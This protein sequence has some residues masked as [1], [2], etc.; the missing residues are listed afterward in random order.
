[1]KYD[2]NKRRES[3]ELEVLCSTENTA[4]ANDANVKDW[5]EYQEKLAKEKCQVAVCGSMD[6]IGVP[7]TKKGTLQV[8][9]NRLLDQNQPQESER[10]LERP[11]K[12]YEKE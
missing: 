4:P 8:L 1:M 3:N 5:E 9:K 6:P 7:R 11:T 2:A 10:P 12:F